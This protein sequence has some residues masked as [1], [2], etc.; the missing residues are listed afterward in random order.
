M[1]ETP[2]IP[3]DRL[4]DVADSEVAS[5]DFA[6]E[7]PPPI[8]D[9]SQGL[10]HYLLLTP[11]KLAEYFRILYINYKASI[12]KFLWVD[13]LASLVPGE[14]GALNED[15]EDVQNAVTK[16]QH[17]L[18]L[19]EGFLWSKIVEGLTPPGE[20]LQEAV[21][22]SLANL[23]RR[24]YL[25]FISFD[26]RVNRAKTSTYRES[27][28]I[29]EAM[30]I[31]CISATGAVEAES[32]A[33]ALVVNGHAD[34]VASEDTV[35]CRF[36]TLIELMYMLLSGRSGIR[37]PSDEECYVSQRASRNSLWRRYQF[38]PRS[39]EGS[40]HRSGAAYGYGLHRPYQKYRTE[41]SV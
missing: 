26:K 31:P 37:C 16:S 25:M 32:L 22:D 4:T 34:F 1:D 20:K 11:D 40:L 2:E 13:P 15:K 38:F 9:E 24:S 14:S 28:E 30:G 36:Q 3:T 8:L 23:V 5:S 29:L 6:P 33:S 7:V 10:S 17:D 27:I 35:R 41:D 39:I 19:D 12:A 21:E 18:A